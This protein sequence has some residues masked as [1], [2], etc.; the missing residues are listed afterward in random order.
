M[1][2]TERHTCNSILRRYLDR[3]Q[4][5]T[6]MS[7]THQSHH[8]TSVRIGISDWSSLEVVPRFKSTPGT[9]AFDH[10]HR[11][12]MTVSVPSYKIQDSRREVSR[13][14]RSAACSY[15]IAP[16]LLARR[17]HWPWQFPAWLQT[18]YLLT[19]K[20]AVL[21]L[22]RSWTSTVMVSPPAT[23]KLQWILY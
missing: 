2:K 7:E 4:R 21:R 17:N 19:L 12:Q 13:L 10:W 6:H 3:R 16:R 11:Q 15:A 14:I 8:P 20:D 22:K 23:Q 1:D 18:R 5:S 9:S